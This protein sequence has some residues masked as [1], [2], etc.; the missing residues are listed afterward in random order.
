M[1]DAIRRPRIFGWACFW[2]SA[3]GFFT[4]QLTACGL[5]PSLG[6]KV[7]QSLCPT[8]AIA[9]TVCPQSKAQWLV[10]VLSGRFWFSPLLWFIHTSSR[11]QRPRGRNSRYHLTAPDIPPAGVPAP[12]PL[13]HPCRKLVAEAERSTELESEENQS[14]GLRCAQPVCRCQNVKCCVLQA[15]YGL[16]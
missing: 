10:L 2:N 1:D 3:A 16:L 8:T 5:N 11:S 13:R 7:Q 14:L 12:P 15:K 4:N 6:V 9:L